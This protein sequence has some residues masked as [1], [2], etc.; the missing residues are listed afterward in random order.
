MPVR[1]EKDPD[2]NRRNNNPTGP[3]NNPGG[4]GGMIRK[5]L[6]FLIMFLFKRPKL[7]LPVLII[8]GLWYFFFGGQAMLSGGPTAEDSFQDASFSL[9]A[10]LSEEM[11]D[12]AKVFEPLSYGYGGAGLPPR[13]SLQNY[14]PRRLHQGQHF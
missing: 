2:N 6:P 1:M 5:L 14:A 4:G 3:R 8:G 12:Q 11:F 9:G 13:V 7:I 10:S